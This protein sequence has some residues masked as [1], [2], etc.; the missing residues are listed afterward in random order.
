MRTGQVRRSV[1]G[2]AVAGLCLSMVMNL[3]G[4]TLTGRRTLRLGIYAGSPWQVHESSGYEYI[5]EAI[6][7]FKANHPMVDVV[8]ESGIRIN[9]Y[10]QWLDDAVVMGEVPDVFVMPDEKFGEY[11]SLGVLKN[12]D[13]YLR[14]DDSCSESDFFPAAVQ[15]G[16]YQYSQ[17]ALPYM[18]NP[19]LMFVNVSLLK[20]EG[21]KV[22]EESWTPEQF[23][24]LCR[25]LTRDLNHDGT[26][27]QYGVV[28]YDWLDLA[29]ASGLDLFS[30]DGHNVDLRGDQVRKVT[31]TYRQLTE[32]MGSQTEREVLMEAGRV[33][34]APMSYAEFITYNPWPWKVKKY[35]GFD[36]ICISLP[37]AADRTIRYAG[38]SL[39]MGMSAGTRDGELAWDLMKEFCVNQTT[40]TGILEHSQGMC[41]LQTDKSLLDAFLDDSGLSGDTVRAIMNQEGTRVRFAKYE[42]AREQLAD[43]MEKAA[44]DPEDLD[45][46]LVEIEETIR[47][48]LRS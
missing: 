8:Y 9:D 44:A 1:L 48:Y 18:M 41:V 13:P 30:D 6:A 17:Y 29:E 15:S 7:R 27:D 25:Q 10:T 2:L 20:E 23:L 39:V 42:S 35:S 5:D 43:R 11:A 47:S 26:P 19:R 45:L 21:L 3:C 4:C 32:F 16:K 33:A 24:A 37:Q 34:F 14:Q 31:E 40:Q 22:P 46:Q 28:D 12:L 36:W 38:N